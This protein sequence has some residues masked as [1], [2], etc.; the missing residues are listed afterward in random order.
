MKH[1]P[2]ANDDGAMDV[3]V[4]GDR[5]FDSQRLEHLGGASRP[6]SPS[7][8]DGIDEPHNI[9]TQPN[10][11][12]IIEKLDTPAIRREKNIRRKAEKQRQAALAN[13]VNVMIISA[14]SSNPSAK[15][16]TP[17]PME[18]AAVV[19]A[20]ATV[21]HAQTSHMIDP[22]AMIVS[23]ENSNLQAQTTLSD[24]CSP[25]PVEPILHPSPSR[26]SEEVRET[27]QEDEFDES[28]LSELSSESEESRNGGS[29]TDKPEHLNQD[30]A[31]ISAPPKRKR[32]RPRKVQKPEA[33]DDGTIGT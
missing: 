13:E 16:A 5:S 18:Q 17:E 11:V 15:R 23:D 12:V 6:E 7:F 1:N 28:E 31:S 21:E 20:A 3:D 26:Q 29:R 10:G 30:Q 25:L 32:G 2:N 27:Q 8:D 19:T 33:Y 9:V 22:V 24:I 14:E 4:P